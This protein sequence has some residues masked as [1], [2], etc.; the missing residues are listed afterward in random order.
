MGANYIYKPELEK[1]NRGRK[2]L[3]Y[4]KRKLTYSICLTPEVFKEVEKVAKFYGVNFST[5]AEVGIKY[6]LALTYEKQSRLLSIIKLSYKR[7][8]QII[9]ERIKKDLKKGEPNEDN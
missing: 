2:K 7:M 6:Y 1:S 5:I 4:S 9:K 3:A 8:K